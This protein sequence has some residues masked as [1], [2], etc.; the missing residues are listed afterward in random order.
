MVKKT[1]L[2]PAKGVAPIPTAKT[3]PE[4]TFDSTKTH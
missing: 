2:P 1:I 3:P 4:R